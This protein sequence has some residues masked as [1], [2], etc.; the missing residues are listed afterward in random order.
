MTEVYYCACDQARD[1]ALELRV[2]GF[3]LLQSQN[4]TGLR[5][6]RDGERRVSKAVTNL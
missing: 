3:S 2:L 6:L 5:R 1:D 4:Q